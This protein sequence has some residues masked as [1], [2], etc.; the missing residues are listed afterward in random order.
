MGWNLCVEFCAGAYRFGFQGQ[1]QDDEVKGAGNSVNYKYRVHDPRL[2]RF[3]SVDPL[4]PE[5]PWNSPYAFS[6]NRVIDGVELEGLEYLDSDDARVQAIDG[7]L[8][9][10]VENFI[11]INRTIWNAANENPRNWRSGELGTRSTVATFSLIHS[12]NSVPLVGS[13]TNPNQAIQAQSMKIEDTPKRK[14]GEPDRRF[15]ANKINEA[16]GI[17][18]ASG[19]RT[20]A[21]AGGLLAVE[22]INTTL[23]GYKMGSFLYDD[24]KIKSHTDIA[25]KAVTD[26]RL[27][28]SKG[29]DLSKGGIIPSEYLNLSDLSSITNVVL[30]GE[31][32]TDN[33]EIYEIGMKIYNSISVGFSPGQNSTSQDQDATVVKHDYFIPPTN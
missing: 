21:A 26:V 20:R 4:A 16:G 2:G 7:K 28:I 9:L 25:R 27:A 15:K 6:E 17:P 1:E 31:N 33:P 5:Y 14:D 23:Q 10:K 12:S 13:S 11:G 24:A 3:M 32:N 30:Q 22:L 18:T 29:Q 19:P 8:V